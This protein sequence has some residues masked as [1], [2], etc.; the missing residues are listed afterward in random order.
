MEYVLIAE[1]NDS[2]ETAHALGKLLHSRRANM[3][4]NIIPYNPTLVAM[5]YKAPSYESTKLFSETV[6]S[7]GIQ[8]I[9]RQELGQDIAGACGQLVV[10]TLGG[11]G[12]V[13]S[14]GC[15]TDVEDMCA[16]A[17][18]AGPGAG[19]ATGQGKAAGGAGA[20][21]GIKRFVANS[22]SS[23]EA[24]AS[25]SGPACSDDSCQCAHASEKE[26]TDKPSSPSTS[27]IPST[28]MLAIGGAAAA[29]AAVCIVLVLARRR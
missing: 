28:R 15:A 9:L 12:A 16:G 5:P 3:M 22:K 21:V 11:G 6:R 17:A 19:V 7:H 1:I 24:S 29:A 20:S 2:E 18:G 13:G 10:S 26:E 23:K 4:L 14:G 27:R 8:V 25:E